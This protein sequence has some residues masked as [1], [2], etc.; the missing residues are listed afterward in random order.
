LAIASYSATGHNIP[1]I[2]F[3]INLFCHAES[4]LYRSKLILPVLVI[5]D[6]H[7]CFL[8]W[9]PSN[10]WFRVLVQTNCS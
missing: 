1:F 10:Q 3:F 8:P 4:V 6:G 2:S 9:A 5:C 7:I